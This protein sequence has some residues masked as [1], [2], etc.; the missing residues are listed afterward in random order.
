M[1]RI[2]W[3]LRAPPSSRFGYVSAAYHDPLTNKKELILF[4]GYD[5]TTWLND[6]NVY[7][8]RTHCASSVA[9]YY[10]EFKVLSFEFR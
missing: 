4:A 6:M 3:A 10:L 9:R 1:D 7:T 8:V 5:G 2:E